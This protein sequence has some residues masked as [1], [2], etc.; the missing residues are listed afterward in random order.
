M[1]ENELVKIPFD[2][3]TRIVNYDN[4]ENP[5]WDQMLTLIDSQEGE[6]HRWEKDVLF[7]IRRENDDHLFGVVG[8][9]GLT[10]SIDSEV[11]E[12]WRTPNDGEGNAILKPV[13]KKQ[14]IVEYYDFEQ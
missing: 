14:K 5:M 8:R 12:E 9:R 3:L 4:T 6:E 1:N 2:E 10:E 13:V 11:F 7:I